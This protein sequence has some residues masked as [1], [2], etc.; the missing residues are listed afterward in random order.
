MCICVYFCHFNSKQSP[1]L[2]TQYTT[3]P[4]SPYEVQNRLLSSSPPFSRLA[5]TAN[6]FDDV[7]LDLRPVQSTT[8]NPRGL[9]IGQTSK[10][11]AARSAPRQQGPGDMRMDTADLDTGDGFL[12][13]SQVRNLH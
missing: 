9:S 7:M 12:S 2:L 6:S 3:K 1:R 10:E 8:G 13:V 4:I 5:F 11:G